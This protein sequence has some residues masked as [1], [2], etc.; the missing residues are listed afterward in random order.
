MIT[1]ATSF[2]FEIVK[3]VVQLKVILS[4]TECVC[5]EDSTEFTHDV[6]I[7]A[8]FSVSVWSGEDTTNY[9]ETKS[10]SSQ[11]K[12]QLKAREEEAAR[13]RRKKSKNA[14]EFQP[15]R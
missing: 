11:S 4:S 13:E 3:Q 12:K 2:I 6:C 7:A 9:Q 1:P 14:K 15:P 8:H 10:A 5:L